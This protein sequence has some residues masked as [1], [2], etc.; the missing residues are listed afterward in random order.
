MFIS[1]YRRW[2][3]LRVRLNEK[4]YTLGVL[5][6]ITSVILIAFVLVFGFTSYIL[7]PYRVEGSSMEPTL[8]ENNRLFI[9]RSGKIFANLIGADYVPKR[10]EMVVFIEDK[11]NC[12]ST[13]E[14]LIFA[15][16]SCKYIK[17]VIGLPNERI[18][19]KN[20]TITIYNN[21][22]PQ[23]FQPDFKLDPPLEDYPASQPVIDR[24]IEQGEIFVLGD[25]RLPGGST[26][27]RDKRIGNVPVGSVEGVVFVRVIPFKDFKLY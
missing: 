15:I 8:Q 19:I 5:I 20:N 6:H 22:F 14:S 25:N 7:Q 27:S 24:I 13:E 21:E 1:A 17:R 26:D 18:V 12:R 16:D 11:D 4:N 9:L 23:G 2:R 10:G 3:R